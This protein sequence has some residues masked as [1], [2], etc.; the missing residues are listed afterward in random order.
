MTVAPQRS[1]CG[2][3]IWRVRP[4]DT[5]VIVE[6]NDKIKVRWASGRTSYYPRNAIPPKVHLQPPEE[7]GSPR[8]AAI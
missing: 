8:K 6:S 2:W 4:D 7:Y 5:G 3:R 1:L